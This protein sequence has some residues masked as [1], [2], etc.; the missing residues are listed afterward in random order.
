MHATVSTVLLYCR[1]HFAKLGWKLV[2]DD[3]PDNA[4]EDNGYIEQ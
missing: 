4:D 3:K 1:R 2:T